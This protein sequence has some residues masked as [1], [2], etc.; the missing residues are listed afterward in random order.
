[1]TDSTSESRNDVLPAL[2][3]GAGP[4]GL[5]MACELRRHG[6]TCRIVDKNPAPQIWSK[7]AAVS[8]RTMEVFQ[9]MGVAVHALAIGRPVFGVNIY[10]GTRRIAHIDIDIPGTP[11]PYIFGMSQRDTELLLGAH[12]S[13]LGGVL[14][15]PVELI[16]F[17]IVPADD[18]RAGDRGHEVVCATLRHPDG[19]E[20]VVYT[21]W[22][23]GCDGARSTVR[24]LLD[25]PFTGTTF[26]QNLIQADMRVHFPFSVDDSEA[27]M[28]IS[29]NGPVG[30]LPLL[31]EGRYRVIAVGIGDAADQPEP[32]F[33]A[34]EEMI[35]ARAPAGVRISDPVWTASFRFH[36]RI[37]DNYRHGRVFLAGDA[38]HIHSPVGGQGMNMGIQD[39]YNLAWKLALV[40]RG[41][42]QP[43]LLDSYH[44]ERWPVGRSTVA[45]TD[46]ATKSAMRVMTLRSPIAQALRNQAAS[47]L[48]NTGVLQNRVFRGLGGMTIDYSASPICGEQHTLL[49]NAHVG[50]RRDTEHA[51]LSDW[52]RFAKGPGPGQRVPDIELPETF[53]TAA[54][55][56]ELLRGT[57]HTLLLFDGAAD[58]EA[59]YVN[60]STIAEAALA[61][62]GDCLRVHIILPHAEAPPALTWRDSLIFDDD[63]A[64]HEHFGCGA[65]ALYVIRP[66]SYVGFR[67]QPADPEAVMAYLASILLPQDQWSVSSASLRP[68]TP[69]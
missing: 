69:G 49:W 27:Q 24:K 46:R 66:D 3:V 40:I 33:E 63:T 12:L 67:C 58:T 9:D 1:M 20:E 45:L 14:E 6:V 17:A 21:D 26:E 48:F 35:A 51:H 28:F 32:P 53:E 60:L 29:E 42:G 36:G 54:T 25:V 52:Y 59:G 55:L 41:R 68:P 65:E 57:H 10:T 39:A 37:V 8:A 18:A 11:Y 38:G 22:L 7:A 31:A 34:F 64:I 47:L 19:R 16:D 2:I 13:D 30:M 44:L 5:T 61:R 50:H 43:T 56:F 62:F 15:R 4:V 23:L